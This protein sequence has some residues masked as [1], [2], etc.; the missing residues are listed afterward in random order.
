VVVE[1][2]KG[3][4]IFAGDVAF[5]YRNLEKDIP[6]GFNSN[7]EE[8]FL[9]MRRIRKEAD[10]VIPGHDPLVLERALSVK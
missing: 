4:V 5:T 3:R 10:I 7:L 1:T 6:V 8:C 2:S 9:A